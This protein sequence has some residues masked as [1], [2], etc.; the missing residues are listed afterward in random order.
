MCLILLKALLAK[1]F[2]QTG[3]REYFL[4]KAVFFVERHS[5]SEELLFSCSDLCSI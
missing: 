2:L 3:H 4:N 1:C 5:L